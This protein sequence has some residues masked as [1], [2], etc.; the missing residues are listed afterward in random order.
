MILSVTQIMT[1]PQLWCDSKDL[2]LLIKVTI[3]LV[4]QGPNSAGEEKEYDE[5]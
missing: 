1:V 3:A 5:I 2:F 4:Y